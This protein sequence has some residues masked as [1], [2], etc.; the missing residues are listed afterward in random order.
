M[1]SYCIFS[2]FALTSDEV[3]LDLLQSG[4]ENVELTYNRCLYDSNLWSQVLPL[5]GNNISPIKARI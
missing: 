5:L 3:N 2:S 1:S 4:D